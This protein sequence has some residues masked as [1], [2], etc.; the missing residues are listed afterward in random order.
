MNVFGCVEPHDE[1]RSLDVDVYVIYRIYESKRNY[2]AP[3]GL[4]TWMLEHC[5]KI[6]TKIIFI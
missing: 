3:N 5:E 2:C 1:K 4:K 6:L